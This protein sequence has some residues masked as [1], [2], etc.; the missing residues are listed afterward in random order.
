MTG[1][2]IAST[3]PPLLPR[4]LAFARRLCGDRHDADDLVQR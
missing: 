4:L 2:D 1:E 3:L